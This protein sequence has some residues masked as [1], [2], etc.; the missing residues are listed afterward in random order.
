[1]DFT[2][3][4]N[5]VVR[6][7]VDPLCKQAC[8]HLHRA[9]NVNTV[10]YSQNDGVEEYV[11]M[12]MIRL[13]TLPFRL[14]KMAGL[15]VGKKLFAMNGDLVFLRPFSEVESLLKQCFSSKGPVRVLV[16]TKPRE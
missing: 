14:S 4:V 11:M 12:N 1:M 13:T 15:E 9:Y 7:L 3:I 10:L 5:N 2:L 6:P 16:S 8:T